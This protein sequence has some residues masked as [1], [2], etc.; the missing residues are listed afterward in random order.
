M[1]LVW[2][3]C[4]D[5]KDYGNEYNDCKISALCM[6]LGKISIVLLSAAIF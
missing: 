6:N 1:C 4:V 2:V 5:G 3:G